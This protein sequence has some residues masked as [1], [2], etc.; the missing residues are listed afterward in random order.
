MLRQNEIPGFC[1]SCLCVCVCVPWG[2]RQLSVASSS[3]GDRLL[4]PVRPD[5]EDEKKKT[6]FLEK[7]LSAFTSVMF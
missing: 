3:C 2:C 5:A 4:P 1:S 7:R 6:D